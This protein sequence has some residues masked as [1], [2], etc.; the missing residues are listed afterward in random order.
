M[1]SIITSRAGGD[2]LLGQRIIAHGYAPLIRWQQRHLCH[3]QGAN[4]G[5]AAYRKLPTDKLDSLLHF[6]EPNVFT[7]AGLLK[8]SQGLEA[9]TP[10]LHL[11]VDHCLSTLKCKTRQKCAC[12]LVRVG[13]CLLR[14]PEERRFDHWRQTF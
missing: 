10:V 1:V 8:H 3:Y 4:T 13:E 11:Q 2:F 7:K 5:M 14:N 6:A 9:T 12:V